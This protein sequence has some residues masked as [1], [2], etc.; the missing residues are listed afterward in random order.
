MSEW[1]KI[2]VLVLVHSGLMAAGS[3]GAE[4]QLNFSGFGTLATTHS[5]SRMADYRGSIMQPNG[6]G[7]SSPWAFGVDTKAGAQ[8][9]A[10]WGGGWSGAAQVVADHRYDNSYKPQFEWANLKYQ[11]SSNWYARAGRVVAPVFMVSDYR[12]VGYAQTAVRQ[13]YDVYEMNPLTHIDGGDVGAQYDVAGGVLSAQLTVGKIKD[14]AAITTPEFRASDNFAYI[15]GPVKLFN[16][17]YERNGATYRAGYGKYRFGVSSN[18][19][20]FN[21]YDVGLKA[22]QTAVS[23]YDS[24]LKL[25]RADYSMWTFGYAYDA[26]AWLVQTEYAKNSERNLLVP[27]QAAWYLLGGYR[28]GKFTPYASFSKIVA[29]PQS[30]QRPDA[31]RCGTVPGCAF[32]TLV[33]TT[34]DNGVAVAREQ[35]TIAIGARYD[36]YRNLAFKAQFEHVYKPAMN[37]PNRG[38]FVNEYR[39]LSVSPKSTF[40]TQSHSVNLLTLALDFV[41]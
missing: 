26:G 28:L 19:A 37:G 32:G 25:Q 33:M 5:N 14:Y 41:F 38:L 20:A 30:L 23:D 15:S 6:A 22:Y 35:S 40:L 7:I 12:N 36:F 2:V 17:A 24:N 18:I 13:P 10:N 34:V 27:G 39:D 21:M 3:A 8:V 31:T 16:V 11:F 1:K 29:K 4:T 9:L